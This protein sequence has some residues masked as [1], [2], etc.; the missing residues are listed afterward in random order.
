MNP[1]RTKTLPCVVRHQRHRVQRARSHQHNM[2]LDSDHVLHIVDDS[3]HF[4][5][6]RFLDN[7]TTG[8]IWSTLL[9]CWEIIYTGMSNR[10]LVDQG[11][12]FGNQFKA[13][14]R[15]SRIDVASTGVKAH[16]SFGI[17]ERYRQP[18]RTTFR[19]LPFSHPN[20]SG[21]LLL[22]MSVKAMK[23]TLG[24]EGIVPS[25][26]VFGEFQQIRA[27]GDAVITRP[28]LAARASAATQDLAEIDKHMARLRLQRAL[29]QNAPPAAK[30]SYQADD[31]FLIWRERLIAQRIGEWKGP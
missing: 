2:Y 31:Q 24:P 20:I 5:T 9:E 22:A 19:K 23:H 28:D 7:F 26:L 11:F 1:D 6:A 14:G 30:V 15:L 13:F 4:S 25:A 16:S 3:T 21:P 17:G 18:L 12:A 8:T 10:I 27:T 29:R